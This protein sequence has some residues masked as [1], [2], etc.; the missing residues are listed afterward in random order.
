MTTH[1]R[2]LPS[3]PIGAMVRRSLQIQRP[4]LA[5]RPDIGAQAPTIQQQALFLC[6]K[7]RVM[8]A[9]RGIPSGMPGSFVPGRPTR[10]Q[11]PPQFAWPRTVTAPQTKEP[12][13]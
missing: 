1:S 8:A 6:L 12:Y 3:S 5:V 7:F 2:P 13:P 11:L 9:V 4:D 10:V